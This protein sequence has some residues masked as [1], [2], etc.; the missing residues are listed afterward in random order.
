MLTY[1]ALGMEWK[2]CT[3][4]DKVIFHEMTNFKDFDTTISVH[5]NW[6]NTEIAGRWW[7]SGLSL[8]ACE[9]V[10]KQRSKTRMIHGMVWS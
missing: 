10:E 4:V 1:V 9:Y 6:T 3:L 7:N 8:L 2:H 5:R